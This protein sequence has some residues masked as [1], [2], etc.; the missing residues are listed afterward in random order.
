M[1]LRAGLF[2]LTGLPN[3]VAV[4]FCDEWCFVLDCNT[5]IQPPVVSVYSNKVY[6]VLDR[7][8]LLDLKHIL[9]VWRFTNPISCELGA[10][11]D[12][13]K[14]EEFSTL[15]GFFPCNYCF[16]QAV[17]TSIQK[18]REGPK[19]AKLGAKPTFIDY[20]VHIDLKHNMRQPQ[21]Q[22]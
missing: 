5:A 2:C 3:R 19:F 7:F 1:I 8:C 6:K 10:T 11:L 16:S 9:H 17:P 14:I 18:G 21:H 13:A 4:L 12:I 20:V 22:H 15:R